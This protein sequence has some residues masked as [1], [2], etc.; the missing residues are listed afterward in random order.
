MVTV[1]YE[2]VPVDSSFEVPS[3]EHKYGDAANAGDTSG[4]SD[5][6]ATVNIRY[7]EPSEDSSK[8][9][10]EVVYEKDYVKNMSA[11]MSLASAVALYG[12][13][14]KNSDHTGAGNYDLVSQLAEKAVENLDDTD[15]DSMK[16]ETR[17]QFIDMVK[18]TVKLEI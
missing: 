14:L 15:G 3:A 9:I 12:M 2:V 16:T 11:D 6:L 1:L 13:L 7:K 4:F 17:K 8:L 5:E 18:A 10:S